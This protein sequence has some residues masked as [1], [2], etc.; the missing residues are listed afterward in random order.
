[1]EQNEDKGLYPK[2]KV[3]LLFES[4]NNKQSKKIIITFHFFYVSNMYSFIHLVL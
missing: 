3:Y 4:Y 1:M 2:I